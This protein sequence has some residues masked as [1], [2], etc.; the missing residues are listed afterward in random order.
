MGVIFDLLKDIP[1]SAALKERLAL[2]DDRF[3]A[4][5]S[6]NDKLI[7][8]NEILV[9]ENA[10]LAS[11]N[12]ILKSKIEVHESESHTL[13]LRLQ[14]EKN[15]NKALE[16]VPHNFDHIDDLPEEL[17]RLLV[18]AAKRRH[19]VIPISEAATAMGLNPLMV[20][21]HA[22]E[23]DKLGLGEYLTQQSIRIRERFHATDAGIRRLIEL[24]RL[25]EP[26][27]SSEE[28]LRRRSSGS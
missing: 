14:N 15:E 12:A 3:A 22:Q 18:L 25:P 23:L 7:A 24:N 10:V 13:Q 1:V 9:A 28:R 21:T 6:E 26:E 16:A 8:Q 19:Q 2:A 17:I 27:T 5:K 20:R 11:Q 4:L